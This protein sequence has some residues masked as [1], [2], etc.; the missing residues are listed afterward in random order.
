MLGA[1]EQLNLSLVCQMLHLL[2][3]RQRIYNMKINYLI[4]KYVNTDCKS[5]QIF[6]NDTDSNYNI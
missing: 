2:S 1:S 5:D 3:S 4:F 6:I